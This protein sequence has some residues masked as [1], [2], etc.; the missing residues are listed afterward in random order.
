MCVTKMIDQGV[1]KKQSDCIISCQVELG[2]SRDTLMYAPQEQGDLDTLI[3]SLLIKC[4]RGFPAYRMV[5]NG[6]AS[7]CSNRDV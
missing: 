2:L 4:F 5:L 7:T 1:N 6:V 3:K